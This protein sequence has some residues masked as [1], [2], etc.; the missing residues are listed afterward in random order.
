MFSGYRASTGEDEIV[1]QQVMLVVHPCV[2]V[3]TREGQWVVL[4]YSSV[5]CSLK[6]ASLTELSTAVRE[7]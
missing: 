3:C 6:V 7:G 5:P 4:L 2:F 1:L